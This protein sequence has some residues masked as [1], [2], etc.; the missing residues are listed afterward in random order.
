MQ[1]SDDKE[2][3]KANKIDEEKSTLLISLK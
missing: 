1:A 2:M 3:Q